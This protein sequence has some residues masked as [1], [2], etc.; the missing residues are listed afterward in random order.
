LVT[1]DS[2]ILSPGVSFDHWNQAIIK[3]HQ[4]WEEE[5]SSALTTVFKDGKLYQEIDWKS[6][7][8]KA[9]QRKFND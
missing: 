4:S 9:R 8:T 3:D 6:L 2:P 7:T 1:P 5:S